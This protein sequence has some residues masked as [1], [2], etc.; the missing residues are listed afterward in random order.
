MNVT[1]TSTYTPPDASYLT[2]GGRITIP[3]GATSATWILYVPND[4]DCVADQWQLHLTASAAGHTA[5]TDTIA[6]WDDDESFCP[7]PTTTTTTTTTP[8]D[9]ISDWTLDCPAS[10]HLTVI[11]SATLCTVAKHG[12]RVADWAERIGVG[13]PCITQGIL[14][15]DTLGV[16]VRHP[17]FGTGAFHLLL[18][19]AR[20]GRCDL[21]VT[22][23]SDISDPNPP[24]G[25]FLQIL[26][27]IDVTAG[28]GN[29]DNTEYAVALQCFSLNDAKPGTCPAQYVEIR[30]AGRYVCALPDSALQ[31]F[32]GWW[33][34]DTES[35]A[36]LAN[37]CNNNA[38]AI[39]AGLVA[40]GQQPTGQPIRIDVT[41]E[42][43]CGHLRI[44]F[45]VTAVSNRRFS[46]HIQEASHENTCGRNAGLILNIATDNAGIIQLWLRSGA[47]PTTACTTQSVAQADNPGV[48]VWWLTPA[49][50]ATPSGC[51]PLAPTP[52]AHSGQP[53]GVRTG[54]ACFGAYCTALLTAEATINYEATPRPDAQI[55]DLQTLTGGGQVWCNGSGCA[56]TPA[57]P[58]ANFCIGPFITPELRWCEDP[59]LLWVTL[60]GVHA[61]APTLARIRTFSERLDACVQDAD[62]TVNPVSW[63][64]WLLDGAVCIIQVSLIVDTQAFTAWLSTK[65]TTECQYTGAAAAQNCDESPFVVR[66]VTWFTRAASSGDCAGI[67]FQF[68]RLVAHLPTTVYTSLDGTQTITYDWTQAGT[69]LDAM[70]P[71]NTCAGGDIA[72]TASETRA[73]VSIMVAFALIVHLRKMR[74][75]IVQ[76]LV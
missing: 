14:E 34:I 49:T 33:M 67:D 40:A 10:L 9:T 71:G 68:D 25:T 3:A 37:Q 20:S 12:A 70:R 19:V 61:V 66:P 52:L 48:I 28:E 47:T 8:P 26:I 76:N 2:T 60:H 73:V 13:G 75:S 74:Q 43:A 41:T 27:T 32:S 44:G 15:A 4:A 29:C 72:T 38:T 18:V 57:P 58:V 56:T 63:A 6:I 62:L 7:P 1:I 17:Q 36:C 50:L 30:L 11:S 21:I 31:S 46:A 39:A 64:A 22:V 59:T 16:G 53:L 69:T 5:G 54:S 65:Y 23:R 35:F 55:V 42:A 51:R 45:H 24:P